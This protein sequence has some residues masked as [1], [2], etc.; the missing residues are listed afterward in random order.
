MTTSSVPLASVSVRT[1]GVEVNG[2][3][4]SAPDGHVFACSFWVIVKPTGS[5]LA[6]DGL[7][8]LLTNLRASIIDLSIET[9]SVPVIAPAPSRNQPWEPAALA[10]R[11]NAPNGV[12]ALSESNF[13]LTFAP[14]I[15]VLSPLLPVKVCVN[16]PR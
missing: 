3:P 10:A 13:S 11:S 6:G 14:S 5:V 8:A 2:A 12:S 9:L 7:E 16:S 4:S 1:C 15:L